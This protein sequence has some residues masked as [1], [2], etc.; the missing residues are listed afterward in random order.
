M[1][2]VGVFPGQADGDSPAQNNSASGGSPGAEPL[3]P[4]A[5]RPSPAGA[6]GLPELTCLRAVLCVSRGGAPLVNLWVDRPPG[7]SGSAPSQASG[8]G[9]STQPQGDRFT[10]SSVASPVPAMD[11]LKI[12]QTITAVQM[13]LGFPQASCVDLADGLLACVANGPSAS[14]ALLLQNVDGCVE[15]HAKSLETREHHP[16]EAHS[17]SGAPEALRPQAEEAVFA[18]LRCLAA[19]V[20]GAFEAG[21]R[22]E[23]EDCAAREAVAKKENEE[24]LDPSFALS[25]DHSVVDP[26]LPKTIPGCKSFELCI[27]S[28][29][30]DPSATVHGIVHS[31]M[32]CSDTLVTTCLNLDTSTPVATHSHPSLPAPLTSETPL[33]A[34]QC[35]SPSS[36]NGSFAQLAHLRGLYH[37]V[38][39]VL[40]KMVLRHV[41]GQAAPVLFHEIHSGRRRVLAVT[42]AAPFFG[43][44]RGVVMS[45]VSSELSAAL[46]A[47][48]ACVSFEDVRQAFSLP[49]PVTHRLISAEDFAGYSGLHSRNSILFGHTLLSKLCPST[50]RQTRSANANPL[51]VPG[52]IE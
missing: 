49:F 33:D 52:K 25:G 4:A 47:P 11:T 32:P 51:D 5:A 2:F 41:R 22:R 38:R 44:E 39:G 16:A 43:C 10:S 12:C 30:A 45:F 24:A 35:E 17:G 3:A 50:S 15:K 13:L 14:A 40:S 46:A 29:I 1:A 42:Y 7:E 27:L 21:C 19:H 31:V 48:E 6:D 8:T 20:S 34:A 36:W 28:A 37:P 18:R 23:I 26:S 9:A